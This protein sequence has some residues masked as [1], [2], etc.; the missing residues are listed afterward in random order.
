MLKGGQ[1]TAIS[2]GFA[3][4]ESRRRKST[5][6]EY[7]LLQGLRPRAC[8]VWAN[9]A[10][11]ELSAGIP[12][13][14]SGGCSPP[15]MRWEAPLTTVQPTTIPVSHLTVLVSRVLILAPWPVPHGQWEG[16]CRRLGSLQKPD[17]FRSS[18]TSR[19]MGPLQK[20]VL[21]LNNLV[22]QQRLPARA[23]L[24]AGKTRGHQQVQPECSRYP[25]VGI[26]S[27]STIWPPPPIS[28]PSLPTGPC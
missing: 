22:W 12:A 14:R 9:T 26:Q 1:G 23:R 3:A 11:P 15:P 19:Q 10:F 24:K 5:F 2:P 8:V 28:A 17:T 7:L 27:P 20:W 4:Q 6:I 25:Q 13:Q 18:D 21:C 16:G